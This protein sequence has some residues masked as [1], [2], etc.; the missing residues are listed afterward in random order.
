MPVTISDR[1]DKCVAVVKVTIWSVNKI[2]VIEIAFKPVEI[3]NL[4]LINAVRCRTKPCGVKM[5][6]EAVKVPA[7]LPSVISFNR[8]LF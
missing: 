3:V 6:H 5:G 4:V 8:R 2:T 1:C 7:Q